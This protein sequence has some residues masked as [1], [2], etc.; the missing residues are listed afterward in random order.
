[1]ANT[2][3]EFN[4]ANIN[5]KTSL[6]NSNNILKQVSLQDLQTDDK[7]IIYTKNSQYCFSLLDTCLRSGMLSGG[8]L[9]NKARKAIL[10]SVKTDFSELD[11]RTISLNNKLVFLVED[12]HNTIAHVFTSRIKTLKLSRKLS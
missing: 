4:L 5:A 1:M 6:F 3:D 9:G 12:K 11:N 2:I 8:L 10:L 7:I